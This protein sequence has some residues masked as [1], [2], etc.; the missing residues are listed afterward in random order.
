MFDPKVLLSYADIMG[1]LQKVHKELED[2]YHSLFMDELEAVMDK[3][4]IFRTHFACM[5]IRQD[6]SVHEKVVRELLIHSGHIKNVLDELDSEELIDLLTEEDIDI[7]G[8]T[9]E[10]PLIEDTLKNIA[11][12]KH[13]Q[14]S[15]GQVGCQRYIIS[16]SEDKFSVLFV[17]ALLR[18]AGSWTEQIDMDI[19]PLFETMD[20]M[21]N[22]GPIM[23]DLFQL[24]KYRAHVNQRGETQTMMLGFSDGTKDGGYLQ[25]NW[26]IFKCKETLT[27]V[28]EKHGVRSIFFDGRGGPPA[29][30]GG[31]THRFYA[32]Q[33]DRIS[34]NEIQ[35]TI[36]GQTITSTYGTLEQFNYNCR[37]MIAAGLSNEIYGEENKISDENRQRM[38]ELAQ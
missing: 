22:S 25:A 2:S 37:Q 26:N 30:G 21:N 31:K 27:A 36:Q 8:F 35:I 10:T 15:N 29:R 4:R 11:Q 6:H 16:N 1:S 33:S 13:I 14:D 19:I 23:E 12:L 24:P 18:W 34:N 28:C 9:S 7:S 3:V 17:Y 5:D 20:G 32:A 38:E